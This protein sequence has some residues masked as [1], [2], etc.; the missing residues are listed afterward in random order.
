MFWLPT[1]L[2]PK[3][4]HLTPAV[5]FSERTTRR[6]QTRS[7]AAR[8]CQVKVIVVSLLRK[9]GGSLRSLD[10][11]KPGAEV[12]NAP[13]PKASCGLRALPAQP[14]LSHWQ[15]PAL[16]GSA[17]RTLITQL[18]PS[19]VARKRVST[20]LPSVALKWGHR[21]SSPFPFFFPP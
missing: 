2:C 11:P 5:C 15:I 18:P 8:A 16:L 14:L 10:I 19:Q 7:P 1:S 17:P 4:P 20:V 6:L 3:S 21:K 13:I 9:H 12:A